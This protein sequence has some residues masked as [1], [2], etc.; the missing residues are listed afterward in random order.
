ME[1]VHDGRSEEA[2]TRRAMQ[3]HRQR[4]PIDVGIVLNKL[5]VSDK[6]GRGF[7]DFSFGTRQASRGAIEVHPPFKQANTLVARFHLKYM[8][9][10]SSQVLLSL[11]RKFVIGYRES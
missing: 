4:I 2:R 11:I 5:D 8:Y 1:D 6:E 7:N 9:L 3:L 10:T